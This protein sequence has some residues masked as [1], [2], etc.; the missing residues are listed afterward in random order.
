MSAASRIA[1]IGGGNMAR[2][3]IGGLIADGYAAAR[4]R[5]ADP[6]EGKREE[7]AGRFGVAVF[8]DNATAVAARTRW[9]WPSSRR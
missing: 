6:D 5:V 8:A 7:L 1:F 2:S 4:I 9:S 3:L